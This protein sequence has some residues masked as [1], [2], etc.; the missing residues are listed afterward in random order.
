MTY[1]KYQCLIED[2]LDLLWH[3]FNGHYFQTN[4]SFSYYLMLALMMCMQA[5]V[6]S[7]TQVF[8]VFAK[9]YYTKHFLKPKANKCCSKLV[10]ESPQKSR[11]YMHDRRANKTV[12]LQLKAYALGLHEGMT[13]QPDHNNSVGFIYSTYLILMQTAGVPSISLSYRVCFNTEL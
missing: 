13:W 5:I 9:I 4:K 10:R 3:A 12:Q 11:V 2:Y 8:Q 1:R 7:S 6:N